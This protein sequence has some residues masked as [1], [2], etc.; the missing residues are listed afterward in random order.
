MR[1]ARLPDQC[2]QISVEE[3]LKPCFHGIPIMGRVQNQ[4]SFF[5]GDRFAFQKRYRSFKK[6]LAFY[7]LPGGQERKKFSRRLR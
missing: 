6:R 1:T 2:L 7:A 3:L 5:K 4:I